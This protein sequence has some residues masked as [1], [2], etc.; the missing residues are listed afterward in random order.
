MPPFVGAM[1]G[2]MMPVGGGYDGYGDIPIEMPGLLPV[3]G[4]GAALLCPVALRY[5][6]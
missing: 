1:A 4:D 6:V 2:C 5:W 3:H